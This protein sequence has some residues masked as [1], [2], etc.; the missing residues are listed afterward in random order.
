MALTSSSTLT[1]ALNQ[2][3]DNLS[4]EGNATKAGNALE[5]VRFILACRPKVIASADRNLNYE[6]LLAE[7]QRLEQY[8]RH[9]STSVNRSSFTR[10]RMLT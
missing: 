9:K 10:G 5:A 6:S 2:Y 1:D 4:W 7:K 3:K 8:V